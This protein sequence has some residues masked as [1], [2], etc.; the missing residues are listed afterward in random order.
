MSADCPVF[1]GGAGR[2]GTTLVADLFGVHSQLSPIYETEFVVQLLRE[3][4]GNHGRSR[5]EIEARARKLM[6]IWTE[7]LP[8]RPHNKR[9]YERYLH[10]P[11]HVLFTRGLAMGCLEELFEN[12]RAHQGLRAF[13]RFIN[14][15]FEA[16][17]RADGKPRWINKTPCYVDVLPALARLFPSLR[18]IHCVRD[19]RDV[20]C[21]V[22]NFV[23]AQ[24]A[25]NPSGSRQA[26]GSRQADHLE[27]GHWWSQK[28]M[29]GLRWGQANPSRYMEVRYED[30]L[31]SPESTLRNILGFMGAPDEAREMVAHYQ[32]GESR[33]D[34]SRCGKWRTRFSHVEAEA[35]HQRYGALLEGLGYGSPGLREAG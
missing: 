13:Q 7:P 19:G 29:A 2:S 21:S 23:E 6:D 26:E 33:L 12:L 35:F 4:F 34:M 18:F 31:R 5:D 22:V 10:G 30:L 25:K 15:L 17:T 28:V 11:H 27:G 14:V 32:Q 1:I 9:E 8:H 24:A 16:H 20:A 3:L